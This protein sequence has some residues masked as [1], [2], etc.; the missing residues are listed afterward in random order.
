MT[1]ETGGSEQDLSKYQGDKGFAA[2]WFKEVSIVRDSRQQQSFEKIGERIVK[3][4]KNYGAIMSFNSANVPPGRVQFNILWSN[5]EI[6]KPMCYARMPQVIVERRHKDQDPIGRLAALG[7]ERAVSYMLD[8]QK[9]KFNFT[10]KAIV[11]DR[12]LPGRGQGWV[13]YDCEFMESLDQNGE[14]LV[15]EFGNAVRAPKPLTEKATLD[16]VYWQDYFQSFA[17]TPFEVRWV[18]RRTY[19]SRSALIKRFGEQIGKRVKLTHSPQSMRN[20]LTDEEQEFLQQAEVYEI[21]DK[22][23]KRVIW[24]SE[25]YKEGAL[26]VKDDPL[27]L[28]GFFPCPIPLLATTTTDSMYP[29]ADYVIYERLADELDFITKRMSA[30]T[31]C[32]RYV[33]LTSAALY[34]KLKDVLTLRD[35]QLWPAENWTGFVEKGGFKGAIDWLPFDKAVEALA[36][37]AAQAD[38]IMAQIDLIT[39]IP[40]I[41]RG[42]TDANETAA[43]QQRKSHWVTAKNQY[44][45]EDVQRFCRD[46]IGKFGEIIFEPG[47]FSDETINLM[48]GVSEMT[49]EDQQNWPQALALLR[50]DRLQTF[51]VDIETDSTIAADEE[52]ERNSWMEYLEAMKNIVG[53]VQAISQFRPELMHPIVESAKAAA[54]RL[55]AGRSVE[56]A[57]DNAWQQIE[58]ADKEARENPQP[59]PP[60]PQM[61]RA[62]TEQMKAQSDAQIQQM[63]VQ[64]EEQFR[65][66]ELQLKEREQ[67]LNEFIKPQEL[68]VKLQLGQLTNDI[69]AQDVQ[70]KG[71]G[72]QTKAEIDRLYQELEVFKEKFRQFADT[73]ML[74]LQGAEVAM[75]ATELQKDIDLTERGQELEAMQIL[76]NQAMDRVNFE[77]ETEEM[78]KNVQIDAL[79]AKTNMIKAKNLRASTTKKLDPSK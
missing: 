59:P 8:D 68:Q 12:L 33:G 58:D 76:H 13:R 5:V 45:A 54:R 49:Q 31:D 53:E 23:S 14:P 42:A 51:R 36:P 25:G 21:W 3:N 24:I 38:R 67:S 43:A 62:E 46:V 52:E 66:F 48:V 7:A 79:D 69:K 39:G 57:W 30:L 50:D 4:Y 35:G 19:M 16:Y 75:T 11:E 29:T 1:D 2:R 15:D 78:R 17:R 41:V 65:T 40:D 37:L 61:I 32:I 70:I 71:L 20:K 26:D 18:A 64:Q 44:R 6:L 72:I 34:E 9:D 77:K 28:K 60:D 73:E 22:D 55:R 56:G 10:M 27:K 47:L 74:K 63:K